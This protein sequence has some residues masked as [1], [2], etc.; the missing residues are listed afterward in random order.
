MT[1]SDR[2]PIAVVGTPYDELNGQFSPDGRFVAYETNES[3]RFEIVVQAFPV[4]SGKWQISTGGGVQARWRADGKELYFQAPDGKLMAASVS[5]TG[6]TLAAGTPV[7]LFPAVMATGVGT[8]RQEYVVSRDGRFLINQPV[9][10]S[11]TTPITLI[12]NV[13]LE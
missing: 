3:N 6:A 10:V 2:K 9:Q 11:T 1:G 12:L 7:A 4:A 5:T 13:K 8:N